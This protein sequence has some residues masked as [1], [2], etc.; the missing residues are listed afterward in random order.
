MLALKKL[1]LLFFAI[2]MAGMGVINLIY[3]APRPVIIPLVP[4]WLGPAAVWGWVTGI[5]FIVVA[6]AV[7]A[8]KMAKKAALIMG[9]VMLLFTLLFSVPFQL[10]NYPDHLG[11]WTNPLK[12]LC[13]SGCAFVVAQSTNFTN[14]PGNFYRQLQK[15]APL[16]LYFFAI[17]H[18]LFGIC[19]FLYVQFINS[20]IPNFIP[21]HIFLTYLAGVAL[22]AAGAGIILN[23]QRWLAANLLSATLLLWVL[24]LHIPR[25][26]ADP[27][28]ME[29]N[30]WTSVFEALAFSGVAF[31]IGT[32]AAKQQ[33]IQPGRKLPSSPAREGRLST[34]G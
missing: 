31:L 25:A 10:H 24:L 5:G 27:T 12:S 15:A 20:I 30:E 32:K 7:A 9:W 23:I 3:S 8:N 17:M 1:S 33:A 4:T 29:S 21:G 13:I 34:G 16:G 22:I 28:G 19:H 6:V 14:P 11:S 26:V 18:F 2:G